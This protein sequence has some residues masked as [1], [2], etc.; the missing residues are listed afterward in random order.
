MLRPEKTR[1]KVS[2]VSVYLRIDY[3]TSMRSRGKTKLKNEGPWKMD[4][5]KIEK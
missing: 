1:E 4:H 5:T 3:Q 2:H